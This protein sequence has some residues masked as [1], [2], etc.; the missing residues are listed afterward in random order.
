MKFKLNLSYKYNNC[1]NPNLFFFNG[2]KERIGKQIS[3]KFNFNFLQQVI[4]TLLT[5]S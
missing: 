3:F 2:D 1:R 5:I 4:K